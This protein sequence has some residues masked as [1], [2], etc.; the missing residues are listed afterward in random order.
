VSSTTL[1][2]AQK[3]APVAAVQME[4]SPFVLDVE[5][6]AGTDLLATCRELGV[7]LVA[8]APLGRGLLTTAFSQGEV[9]S[10][11]NDWRDG[12]F[13]R[14]MEENR[15]KNIKL[16]NQFKALADKK[17]CTASQLSIAWLLKQGDDI[18]PI[19]GTKKIKYLEENWGA[20]AVSLTDDE[21][22]EIRKFV[23]T[24]EVAGGRNPPAFSS[25]SYIDTKEES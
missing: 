15:D 1:R 24:A 4:Y 17:G 20:L 2:R 7:A 9:S 18:I 6:T 8:Y 23:E 19:P 13:P 14:F 12:H 11:K 22:D 16:V 3:I 21:E 10:D 25:V 5:G